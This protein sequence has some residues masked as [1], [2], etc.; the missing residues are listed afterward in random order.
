MTTATA[1]SP[2]PPRAEPLL[3]IG[4]VRHARLRPAANRFAYPTYFLMLPMRTLRAH[5]SAALVRNRFGLVSFHDAD[6]GDGGIL[7]AQVGSGAFL[8]SCRNF[9]H[10][11]VAGRHAE[12][13][14]A[15]NDAVEHGESAAGQGDIKQVHELMRPLFP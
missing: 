14:A 2:F 11:L 12:H 7:A 9:D 1:A 10:A 4:E 13:L 8:D 15:G 6:H 3:G 5:P